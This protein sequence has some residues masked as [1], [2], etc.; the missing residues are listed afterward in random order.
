MYKCY[1][2]R[3]IV[4][5][6][7]V[8]FLCP[9]FF[10]QYASAPQ[11]S[12]PAPALAAMMKPD[13]SVDKAVLVKKNGIA[14][15]QDRP[16]SGQMLEKYKNGQTKSITEFYQGKADGKSEAWH[17]TG[18]R[19]EIRFYRHGEKD[20]E[21]VG[22][23]EN[24]NVRFIYHFRQGYY[25]GNVKEWYASGQLFKDFN[26]ANGQEFG[27]ERLWYENGKIRANYVV[28]NG[29][30]FGLVGLKRCDAPKPAKL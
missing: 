6:A 26:Y 21:H 28:K 10:S 9:I 11:T 29:R 1:M 4:T 16:F 2:T 30:R 5:L 20:G 24:G 23:W 14:Y 12:Q 3:V 17:E 19:E 27:S 13:T 8:I 15:F 7:G 22:W 25:E 18:A